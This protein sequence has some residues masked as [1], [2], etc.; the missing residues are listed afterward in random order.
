MGN[1][2]YNNTWRKD[3]YEKQDK[4][5]FYCTR[6]IVLDMYHGDHVIPMSRGGMDDKTNIVVTC[7]ECNM[8]KGIKLPHEWFEDALFKLELAI[9]DVDYYTSVAATLKRLIDF[10]KEA[11]NG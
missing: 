11:S 8:K 5:C 6:K 3:I 10:Q 1:R 9:R 7:V 2:K 4:K